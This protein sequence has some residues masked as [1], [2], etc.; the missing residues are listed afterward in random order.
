M[1]NVATKKHEAFKAVILKVLAFLANVLKPKEL[2]YLFD[3]LRAMPLKD[4]DAAS[5][6][7]LK[8]IAK[9]IAQKKTV[10]VSSSTT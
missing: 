2:R 3:K 8:A 4:H 9:V 10:I 5:L 6:A 7:L 1:W